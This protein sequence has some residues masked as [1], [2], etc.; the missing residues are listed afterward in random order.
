MLMWNSQQRTPVLLAC[1]ASSVR[2]LWD[3]GRKVGGWIEVRDVEGDTEVQRHV[4]SEVKYYLYVMDAE[5]NGAGSNDVSD[6]SV[7]DAVVVVKP[8]L[9][10]RSLVRF[11]PTD[12]Q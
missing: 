9:P 1:A 4:V 7:F 2:Q 8:W 6:G 10:S 5:V 3:D 11:G 12:V